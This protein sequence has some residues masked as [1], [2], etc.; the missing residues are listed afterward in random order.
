PQILL[1]LFSVSLLV[2]ACGKEDGPST[3][4]V[5]P[6]ARLTEDVNGP[7]H[8][9][10]SAPAITLRVGEGEVTPGEVICL[11]FEV[12]NFKNMLGFQYTIRFDSTKF[13]Y[14]EVKNFGLPGYGPPDFG[15]RF[16]SRG[17]LSSLWSDPSLEPRTLADGSKLFDLCLTAIGNSG[18][19]SVVRLSNGPT[20]FEFIDQGMTRYRLRYA[21]G[22]VTIK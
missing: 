9:G 12:T 7:N 13:Q 15:T 17:V 19:E 11:P 6:N 2:A 3:G 21:N 14:K 5:N 1:L 22:K 20:P 8:P 4:Q 16:E 18:E 10:S